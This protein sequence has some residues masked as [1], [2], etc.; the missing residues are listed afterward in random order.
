MF[1]RNRER[2]WGKKQDETAVNTSQLQQSN[3]SMLDLFFCVCLTGFFFFFLTLTAKVK[4][5]SQCQCGA[6][7]L[8]MKKPAYSTYSD[9]QIHPDTCFGDHVD[10]MITQGG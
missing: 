3:V 2:D 4:H 8:H 7:A 5:Q 9:T 1:E 10:H 6:A